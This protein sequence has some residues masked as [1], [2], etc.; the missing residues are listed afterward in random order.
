MTGKGGGEV[1]L[2][3]GFINRLAALRILNPPPP[4]LANDDL[5]TVSKH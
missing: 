1:T 4:P 2:F 3:K 5:E